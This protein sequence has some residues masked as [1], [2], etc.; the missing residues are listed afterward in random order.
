MPYR[1]NIS[2]SILL[3]APVAKIQQAKHNFFV[4]RDSVMRERQKLDPG[5]ML[6]RITI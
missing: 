4:T 6:N 3:P 2:Q 1:R 5:I